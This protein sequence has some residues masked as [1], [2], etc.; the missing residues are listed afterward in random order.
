MDDRKW[1]LGPWEVYVM[2]SVADD[3]TINTSFRFWA[4]VD[5]K[6]LDIAHMPMDWAN[7]ANARLIAA[8]P[9]LYEALLL[10]KNASIDAVNE[11]DSQGFID[12]DSF[13]ILD[14]ALK[15]TRAALAKANP[16]DF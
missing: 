12:V 3:G 6:A 10:L 9:E 4:N 14:G 11:Y 5:G 7:E 16:D 2:K 15:K 1:T 8:A 13:E